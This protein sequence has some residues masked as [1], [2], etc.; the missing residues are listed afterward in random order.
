MYLITASDFG[1]FMWSH[2]IRINISSSHC[3]LLCV[4]MYFLIYNGSQ[5]SWF[6][7][8]TYFAYTYIDSVIVVV[9]ATIITTT[10]GTR[11]YYKPSRTFLWR[12]GKILTFLY[13]L[14][15][16]GIKI[17]AKRMHIAY[18]PWA[19]PTASLTSAMFRLWPHSNRP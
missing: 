3:T 19:Q 16:R 6:T 13:Y 9:A 12:N 5:N 8:N 11:D 10:N 7:N 14:I 18:P 1:G 15:V 17:K 2:F 4:M